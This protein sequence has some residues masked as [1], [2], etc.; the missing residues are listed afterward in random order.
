L[1]IKKGL[2][3]IAADEK[4][5][6]KT[7]NLLE[8]SDDDKFKLLIKFFIILSK[9]IYGVDINPSALK[10]AKARLFLTLAKHFKVGK[11]KDI[12]IRFP[13]V[14]FNLR[15]GN[16]LIGYVDIGKEQQKGQLQLR[17]FVE[18][19]Q[20][21]YITEKIKV[22]SELKPYL[23][24]TA[25][26]LNLDGNILKEVKELNKILA[27]RKIDWNDFEKI[28]KTKEKLITILIASLNSKYAKP[29]N[30]LLRE[31]TNLFNQKLDEKFAE[32]HNIK[33]E[34]LK[35]IKTFHWIFEF[36]EVFLDRGGFDVVVGNPPY[37]TIDPK[38][39]IATQTEHFVLKEYQV[40]HGQADIL[41]FFYERSFYLSREKGI[42]GLISKNRW[43]DSPTYKPFLRFLERKNIK[44]IDFDDT[45]IFVGVGVT[46]N[47]ILIKK[48]K[49]P[50]LEYYLFN[51]APSSEILEWNNYEKIHKQSIFRNIKYPLE[52]EITKY[53]EKVGTV[54]IVDSGHGHKITPRKFFE[55][56]K[57]NENCF[58]P[59]DEE[60]RIIFPKIY[61]DKKEKQYIRPFISSG[62][63]FPYYVSNP[64]Y[65][66]YLRGANLE[67]LPNVKKYFIAIKPKNACKNWYEFHCG[68]GYRNIELIEKKAKI[69]FP[70]RQ[71]IDRKSSFF[72]DSVGFLIGMD[73]EAAVSRNEEISLKYLTFILNSNLLWYYFRRKFKRYVKRQTVDLKKVPIRTTAYK[74]GYEIFVDYL[75][76]LNATKE[77]RQKFKDI[78]EFFDCQIADSLVYEL[79]FKEKFYEDGLYPE[80]KEYLLEEVSKHLK[81]INYDRWAELYWKKQLEGNLTEEEEEE[82][83]KLEKENMKI[84]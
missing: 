58:S 55:L 71:Y 73:C 83:E 8:I 66:F 7:I 31:I 41:V 57:I 36:P 29:L 2:E 72:L 30:E 64:H 1:G 79:Y 34:D 40:Y 54:G 84:V 17:L 12:F 68:K 75:L 77:R 15:E 42:I 63:L 60:I 21:E 69:I 5:E 52:N 16:S 65:I 24:K 80:P 43:Q 49:M 27:K 44:I 3:I 50:T 39:K 10:V 23:E 25:K 32:E 82:L 61:L 48:Q 47:I 46:T 59:I 20:S 33:L 28:L 18:E 11:E 6:I 22:V 38:Y 45:F 62:G 19:K 13:N 67:N 14:H 76:F 56:Q 74:F 4:G 51:N 70:S 35:K 9:N 26:S 81:P 78:I 53:M 37:H